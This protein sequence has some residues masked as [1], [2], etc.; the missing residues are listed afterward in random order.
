MTCCWQIAIWTA[1]WMLVAVRVRSRLDNAE[2]WAA[3]G[4]VRARNETSIA[5]LMCTRIDIFDRGIERFDCG[6]E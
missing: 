2:I 1:H 5:S 4:C 3:A 6:M